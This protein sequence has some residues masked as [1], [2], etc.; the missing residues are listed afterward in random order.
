MGDTLHTIVVDGATLHPRDVV[1]LAQGRRQVTLA[2]V[3]S[4]GNQRAREAARTLVAAGHVVYGRTTGVGSLHVEP[5]ERPEQADHDLRLFRSHAGGSGPPVAPDL[6]RAALL[7]RLNQLGA[8]GAGVSP[9]LLDAMAS[10]LNEGLAP[11]ARRQGGLGTADL[12]AL[13][14]MGLALVGEGRWLGTG[15]PPAPVALG[16]GDALAFMSSNAFTLGQSCLAWH[17]AVRLV[18][19]ADSVTALSFEVVDGNAE[20][21]DERVQQARPYPGQIAAAAHL[22]SLLGDDRPA[23]ARVQDPISFRCVPQIHGA[24]RDATAA[25]EDVLQT[26]INAA[27]E[28][29]LLLDGSHGPE[30]LHHGNFYAA[31]LG[32][33]LD[34]LRTALVHLAA[35]SARRL[36]ALLDPDLTGLPAHLAAGP[37]ASSGAMILEYTAQSA[38]ARARGL[39]ATLGP[40]GVVIAQGIE[41]HASFAATSAELL[42]E[43]TEPVAI[44]LGAELVAAVRALRMQARSPWMEAC[45]ELLAH[46]RQRLPDDLADRSLAGDVALAAALVTGEELAAL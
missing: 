30:A 37:S 45:R 40:S 31:R 22:R 42:G 27:A 3:A 25:I 14:D 4:D 10:A 20:A 29:P 46:V 12:T 24:A 5:V 43:L 38:L 44:V 6:A 23:S 16:P 28:N 8:G 26:E 39:A 32:L 35:I 19:N 36:S 33:V 1:P 17:T 9:G 2:A 34:Q 18:H 11:S 7:I 41:D 15:R 13:A 21:Y